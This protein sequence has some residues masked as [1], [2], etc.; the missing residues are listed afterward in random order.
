MRQIPRARFILYLYSYLFIPMQLGTSQLHTNTEGQSLATMC[1]CAVEVV[2]LREGQG[3][4][5]ET[6]SCKSE[7]VA[8]HTGK[9][10]LQLCG[11]AGEKQ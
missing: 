3:T 11:R 10:C 1:I 8:Q 7:H 2:L 9:D 5:V 6:V 4:S